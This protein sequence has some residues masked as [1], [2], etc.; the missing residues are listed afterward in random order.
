ML[1]G[2]RKY[3]S[4]SE[5]AKVLMRND[6]LVSVCCVHRHGESV[7]ST[8]VCIVSGSIVLLFLAENR[9]VSPGL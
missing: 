8:H 7:G 2:V 3:E 5:S 9:V 1:K 6:I 4:L